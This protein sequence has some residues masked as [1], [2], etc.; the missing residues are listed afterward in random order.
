MGSKK[1]LAT[2]IALVS[3]P[4]TKKKRNH[5]PAISPGDLLES[6]IPSAGVSDAVA[7]AVNTLEEFEKR[8]GLIKKK[9]EWQKRYEDLSTSNA[10]AAA[11]QTLTEDIIHGI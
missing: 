10:D 3:A 11:Y 1:K 5:G 4:N 8:L 9:K 6:G 2:P 7:Q